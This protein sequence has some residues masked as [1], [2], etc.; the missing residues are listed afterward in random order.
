MNILDQIFVLLQRIIPQHWLSMQMHKLMRC[1]IV[2]IKN[3]IIKN[4]INL[5]NVDMSIAIERNPENFI[6]F[7]DFFVREIE[8]TARPFST[9]RDSISS[10]VDGAVSQ[11]GSIENDQL[12]QAKGKTFSL[13][14]LLANDQQLIDNFI[15]GYFST[16]Y[17]SP[18]DYHRIHMPLDGKLKK[19]IYVPGD[20]FAVNQRTVE[21]V[22]EL[23][24][25]NERT[26]VLFESDSGPFAMI[27]VGAIFV[28]SMETV[29]HE[30]MIT[31]PYKKEIKVWNYDSD[32]TLKKGEEMGRFNMGSTVILLFGK[33]QISWAEN[34]LAGTPIKMGQQIG[35]IK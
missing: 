20:L 1:E 19:M 15:D 22:P 3:F 27:L 13:S 11:S 7:N 26:I 30:E 21:N 35:D 23:F 28:G 6:H 29:W 14:S 18:K 2:P 32:L 9:D 31:P 10:P 12:F 17:L 25:R 34:Q 5:Y 24:A 16:L 33:D 4:F 8:T